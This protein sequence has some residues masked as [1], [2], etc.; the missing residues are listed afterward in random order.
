[1]PTL[2]SLLG[3]DLD[4]VI[5]LLEGKKEITPQVA[6]E[7]GTVFKIPSG[8]WLAFERAYRRSQ[9][10]QDLIA[11]IDMDGTIA[12]Y[13]GRIREELLKLAGPGD[14]KLPGHLHDSPEWLQARIDLIRSQEGFWRGLDQI[15]L[16]FA[17]LGVLREL[18]YTL[19][20]LTKGPAQMTSAWTEKREWCHQHLPQIK[21]TVTE[22][23]GLS[24]GK[25]L[26]DDYPPYIEG[27]LQHRPRGKVIMPNHP[28]NQDFQH[29]QVFRLHDASDLENLQSFLEVGGT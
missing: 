16:G 6:L 2:C 11:L 25:V 10:A 18:G 5:Q 29:P 21:V 22:D 4:D 7:L 3:W 14:P 19:H 9:G 17:V 12:D 1:M 24:Y 8:F 13:D 23:K 26:F 27:W 15:P 28:W 20:V